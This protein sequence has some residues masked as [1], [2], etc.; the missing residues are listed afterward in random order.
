[1][2][3]R[4]L[5]QRRSAASLA[6]LALGGM[7]LTPATVRAEQPMDKLAEQQFDKRKPIYDDV[8]L[9]SQTNPLATP[10]AL[11]PSQPLLTD[12][13]SRSSRPTPTDRLAVHIGR[14]RILLHRYAVAAED[15]VNASMDAAFHLEQSFTDTIASLAPPRGSGERLM[16]GAIYVVV[17]AMAGTIVTR[18]RN[19]LLRVSVPL[20]LGIGAGWAVLP[21]TMRNVADLSWRYE[22]RFPAVADAHVR[23]RE[24]FEKGVHYAKVHSEQ[25]VRYV[26][27]RVT[28]A[29]EAVEGW[30][31]QG[32]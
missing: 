27:E 14:V 17:A 12:Q 2:A 19:V 8:H 7:A 22:Q 29:R 11:P 30:V 1:M 6:V 25:G 23:L 18:N 32:K 15:K 9:S 4:V 28:N 31:K 24:E 13:D 26:D 21:I 16:P 10:I 20:A 5:L 3:A